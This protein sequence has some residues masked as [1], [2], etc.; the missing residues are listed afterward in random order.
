M[1]FAIV[2]LAV[3]ACG[4]AASYLWLCWETARNYT[5]RPNPLHA[6]IE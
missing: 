1:K 2:T 6:H 4:M 5:R 3:I